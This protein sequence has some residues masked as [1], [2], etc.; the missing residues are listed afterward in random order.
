MIDFYKNVQPCAKISSTH[1]TIKKERPKT[2][3]TQ[4]NKQFLKQIGLLK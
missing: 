4:E 2:K 1:R 3:L